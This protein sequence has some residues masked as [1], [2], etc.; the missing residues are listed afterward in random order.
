MQSDV[1]MDN[2]KIHIVN[3]ASQSQELRMLSDSRELFM[4]ESSAAAKIAYNEKTG[5]YNLKILRAPQKRYFAWL[6]GL[7]KQKINTEP[8][9]DSLANSYTPLITEIIGSRKDLD[10][11]IT[12]ALVA[13]IM[14]HEST[15]NPYAVSSVA[16]GLMQVNL[17]AHR[18]IPK[19]QKAQIF[20]PKVNTTI[21]IRILNDCFRAAKGKNPEARTKEALRKYYGGKPHAKGT[22]SYFA[23]VK[24]H[25]L[26]YMRYL[27]NP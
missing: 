27:H 12:P 6:S 15:F 25:Q 7:K 2:A 18:E 5:K 13:G 20:D 3:A 14:R 22:N 16:F 4:Q 9:F 21:G 17:G 10:P 26:S 8:L 11:L 19:D 23:D 1:I 24:L